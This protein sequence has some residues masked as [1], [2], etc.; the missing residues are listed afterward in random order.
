[1]KQ[2]QHRSLPTIPKVTP[3][4][5]FFLPTDQIIRQKRGLYFCRPLVSGPGNTRDDEK[6]S[7]RIEWVVGKAKGEIGQPVENGPSDG[8]W[9]L[10]ITSRLGSARPRYRQTCAELAS[11]KLVRGVPMITR[12]LAMILSSPHSVSLRMG[13][14]MRRSTLAPIRIKRVVARLPSPGDRFGKVTLQ[15][16]IALIAEGA[17]RKPNRSKTKRRSAG[18]R[19]VGGGQG[20]G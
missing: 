20:L 12:L 16:L 11:N 17:N 14:S 8:E 4:S 6:V 18:P 10:L 13:R 5:D 7:T 15:S 19:G 3:S 2:L 9:I 1:M